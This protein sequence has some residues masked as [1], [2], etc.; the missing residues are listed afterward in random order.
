MWIGEEEGKMIIVVLIG[1]AAVGAAV[2]YVGS[3]LYMKIKK[4]FK[5]K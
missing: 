4:K 2:L 1:L 3:W 5:A